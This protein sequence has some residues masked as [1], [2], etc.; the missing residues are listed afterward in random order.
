ME[1]TLTIKIEWPGKS[2]EE[3]MEFAERVDCTAIATEQDGYFLI[4]TNDPVNFYLLGV[5][6]L[7]DLYLNR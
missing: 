6:R 2:L 3:A 4:S 5:T 7:A 1:D